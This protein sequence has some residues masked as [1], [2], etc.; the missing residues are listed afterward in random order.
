MDHGIS[1]D[2]SQAPQIPGVQY[3]RLMGA[4][5]EPSLSP[6]QD[7]AGFDAEDR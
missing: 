1:A 4:A 6:S 5:L 2:A 3:A 7:T